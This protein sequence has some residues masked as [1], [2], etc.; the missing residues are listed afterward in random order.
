VADG[1][2]TA[3]GTNTLS[4]NLANLASKV[5]T[6]LGTYD[7]Q[8]AQIGNAG[9]YSYTILIKS[10]SAAIGYAASSTSVTPLFTAYDIGTGCGQYGSNLPILSGSPIASTNYL[11]GTSYAVYGTFSFTGYT[12]SAVATATAPAYNGACAIT[13][14]TTGGGTGTG[15]TGTGG[16]GTGGTGTGGTGTGGT[17]TG[18]TG[19]GGTGTG[20]TGTGGTGTGGTTPPDTTIPTGG[21][22]TVN[23]G[24]TVT[25]GAG[26]TLEI[27]S[28][29]TGAVIT[30]P[31]PSATGTGGTAAPAEVTL[32]IGGKTITMETSGAT[33]TKASVTTVVDSTGATVTAMKIDSGSASVSSSSAGQ[34]IL[35]LSSVNTGTGGSTT[36][37][38]A[39]TANTATTT[40]SATVDSTGGTSLIVTKGSIIFSVYS[41]VG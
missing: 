32:S 30:L 27:G 2:I 33:E 28:S 10:T 24:G 6:Q 31:T 4:I 25:A 26:S 19:T 40:V 11:S 13:P 34:T 37:T 35:A 20:G 15:G 38:T 41:V 9:N 29:A 3:T 22:G 21:T 12:G 8:L 17:G 7:T 18:G 5:A 23:T 39:V 14:P 36:T 1:P 16:T